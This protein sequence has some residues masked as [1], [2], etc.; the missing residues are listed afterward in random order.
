MAGLSPAT[1]VIIIC[2]TLFVLC[3]AFRPC[4][5]VRLVF[6]KCLA[7]PLAFLQSK[8]LS[9][10]RPGEIP[11]A[12]QEGARIEADLPIILGR[13]AEGKNADSQRHPDIEDP[14]LEVQHERCDDFAKITSSR[15]MPNLTSEARLLVPK[16][17]EP[18][19]N[20]AQVEERHEIALGFCGSAVCTSTV[21]VEPN[22][23]KSGLCFKPS[24]ACTIHVS[25][26]SKEKLVNG[27]TASCKEWQLRENHGEIEEE[28]L[29]AT[30]C[31]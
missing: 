27:A 1:V 28:S 31:I 14:D 21:V 26:R 12:T 30:Q 16:L 23:F 22:I 4:C 8:W 15:V 29:Y 19:E 24:D 13:I 7:L 20:D 9:R 25:C 11:D 6:F 5:R 3:L 18:C 17:P 10:R 2:S